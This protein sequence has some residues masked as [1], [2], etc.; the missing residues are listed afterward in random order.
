MVTFLNDTKRDRAKMA[1]K[2]ISNFDDLILPK[3][4]QIKTNGRVRNQAMQAY[5]A[6]KYVVQL[7]AY[8]DSGLA[9][10]RLVKKYLQHDLEM[11]AQN[12]RLIV[13]GLLKNSV[14]QPVT[15]EYIKIIHGCDLK[16]KKTTLMISRKKQS[17]IARYIQNMGNKESNQL[18][19]DVDNEAGQHLNQI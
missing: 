16:F 7:Y 15:G 12:L 5:L 14:F 8:I 13:K 11:V 17:K 19:N 9:N 3:L 2:V 1:L 10:E 4:R 18:A 6:I